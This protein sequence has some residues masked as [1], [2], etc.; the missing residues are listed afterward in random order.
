[1]GRCLPI[2]LIS[3]LFFTL[4]SGFNWSPL[5]FQTKGF[6]QEIAMADYDDF[7]TITNN[8]SV[9]V[10][11]VVDEQWACKNMLIIINNAGCGHNS[12]T[13]KIADSIPYRIPS[14]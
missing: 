4:V 10:G 1:M 14:Y 13:N 11:Y 8:Q 3:L 9:F 2:V 6:V 12:R 7:I 5:E